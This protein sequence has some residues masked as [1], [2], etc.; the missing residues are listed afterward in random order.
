MLILL[1]GQMLKRRLKGFTSNSFLIVEYF[2][3]FLLPQ[4]LFITKIGWIIKELF[5]LF[6]AYNS[7]Y[8]CMS[9]LELNANKLLVRSLMIISNSTCGSFPIYNKLGSRDM[10]D[11]NP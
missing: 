8:L 2:Q 3:C 7:N 11:I 4:K 9:K 1:D 5:H 10:L 6:S